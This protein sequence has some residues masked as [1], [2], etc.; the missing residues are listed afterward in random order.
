M[1]TVPLSR[2]AILCPPV[3]WDEIG[4]SCAISMVSTFV[5]L[6]ASVNKC[7]IGGIFP[8]GGW[9]MLTTDDAF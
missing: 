7:T 4:A 2:E 9:V 5:T 6:I 3:D 1:L 8:G